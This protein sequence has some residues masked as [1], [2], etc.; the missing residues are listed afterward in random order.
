VD[1]PFDHSFADGAPN[2]RAAVTEELERACRG[3][4]GN[5]ALLA[6][7]VYDDLRRAAA[8]LLRRE[9]SAHTLQPTALV[10]EAWLRL[11]DE[12]MFAGADAAAARRT[13]LSHAVQ[14]MR[15]ILIEH[16]RARLRVKRGGNEKLTS[17]P[18]VL[19]IAIDSA[20]EMLDLDAGLARLAE[21]RPR[22]AK[23]AELRIYGGL[24][25]AEAAD[26]VGVSLAT[27][28]SEWALAQALLTQHVRGG[29]DR[30]GA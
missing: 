4:A 17:L 3:D 30:S 25:T 29:K 9:R 14:A 1:A 11:V 5:G 18:A 23:I 24:S 15:R 12:T 16:A 21:R 26:V 13:F 22:V 19:A 2:A 6:G 28:K 8:S 10:H 7:L 27:A 20:P